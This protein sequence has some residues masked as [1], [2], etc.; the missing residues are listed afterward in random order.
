MPLG[1]SADCFG[2]D[3]YVRVLLFEIVGELLVLFIQIRF[4]L[5]KVQFNLFGLGLCFLFRCGTFLLPAGKKKPYR[6][7][8]QYECT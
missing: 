4:E 1:A 8:K 7:Q 2:G 6:N 3:G 5:E